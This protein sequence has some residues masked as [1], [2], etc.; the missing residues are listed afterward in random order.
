MKGRQIITLPAGGLDVS[1]LISIYEEHYFTCL[2]IHFVFETHCEVRFLSERLGR[3][4]KCSCR[5]A[6][7]FKPDWLAPAGLSFL[8]IILPKIFGL[9]NKWCQAN[10]LIF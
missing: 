6:K 4:Q 2:E 5:F 8:N 9:I 7:S 10:W 1:I 3:E